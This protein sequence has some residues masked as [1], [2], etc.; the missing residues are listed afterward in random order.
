MPTAVLAA[1]LLAGVTLAAY[2][3]GGDVLPTVPELRPV[4]EA[5][6]DVCTYTPANNGADPTWCRG[7]TILVRS[8]EHL[9]ASSLETLTDAKPLNNVRWQ[10]YTRAADGWKLVLADP[11][12]RTREPCPL[13]AFP[14]GRL[15][16]SSHPTL[17]SDRQHEGGGPA[18]PEVLEFQAADPLA[19]YRTLVP[20]W[21]DPPPFSEHSYRTFTADGPRGDFLLMNNVGNDL[22]AWGY[23]SREGQWTTGR[24][25]WPDLLPG[26]VEPYGAKRTRPNYPT[27]LLRDKAVYFCGA[28]AFD[29]WDR[30][31]D[32]VADKEKMG[33]QWGGRWRRLF[34]TWTP[35]ITQTAFQPWVEISNTMGSGGWLFPGDLWVGPDATVHLLWYE[36]A[37]D[38]R[39]RDKYFPDLTV[40]PNSLQYARV[41]DGQVILRRTLLQGGEGVGP[42]IPSMCTRF[43]VTPDNRLFVVYQVAGVVRE[44]KNVSE[45]RVA[46]VRNDGALG[47]SARLN[48]KAPF[49]QFF[50]ATVR[51]GSPPSNT[52]EL[53]G[54]RVG[55][56]NKLVYVR[57]RLY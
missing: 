37:V 12:N 41:R 19:P 57:V 52:L 8:G 47:P 56:P 51:G 36:G 21:A 6:E 46:E 32:P 30:V 50:T 11:A 5:E 24:L 38:R 33:R 3:Q 27:V 29:N 45:S 34:F 48:L 54:T 18:R 14:D 39:L 25:Y 22:S 42:E 53:L 16:L 2:A 7:S 13:V 20:Q 31:K 49:D 23:C 43:Q 1:V 26:D 10:L 28:A 15:L 9:F 44:G 55:E 40:R 17:V 4:V 35:D